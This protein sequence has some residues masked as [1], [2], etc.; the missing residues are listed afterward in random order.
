MRRRPRRA[1]GAVE[2]PA[3]S[4]PVFRDSEVLV[5]GSG[6]SGTAAAVAAARAG[7]D[8][9]LLERANHLS[10]QPTGGLVIRIDRMTD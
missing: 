8:V 2:E 5:I 9:A 6:P 1:G 4:V 3:Q 7:A 10:G